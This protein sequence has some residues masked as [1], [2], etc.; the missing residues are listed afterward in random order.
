MDRAVAV[1]WL[2]SIVVAALGVGLIGMSIMPGSPALAFETS[3]VS[4]TQAQWRWY[5]APPWTPVPRP[6]QQ[7]VRVVAREFA[8]EPSVVR[9][10]GGVSINLEVVNAGALTHI[11]VIPVLGTR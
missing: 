2:V 4:G 10:A 6:V 3:G 8:F 9:V 11:L 1:L 5:P 7:T